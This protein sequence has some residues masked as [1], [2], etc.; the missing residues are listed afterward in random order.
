MP[1]SRTFWVEFI[2]LYKSLP[3]LWKR[4][5]EQYGNKYLKKKGYEL[6]LEKFKELDPDGDIVAVKQRINNMRTAFWREVHRI[7]RSERVALNPED[8]YT[9]SLWY[10][11]HMQF[12]LDEEGGEQHQPAEITTIELDE[13]ED[14]YAPQPKSVPHQPPKKRTFIQQ[15]PN[16]NERTQFMQK[17]Q[18][19][20]HSASWE[21]MYRDLGTQQKL[22]ANRMITEV[23]YQASLGRLQESS[24]K[25]LEMTVENS[26]EELQNNDEEAI[27]SQ[28]YLTESTEND[29]YVPKTSNVRKRH[30]ISK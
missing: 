1:T 7:R 12:L 30:Q 6:M 18:A 21:A 14:D 8:V 17:D 28:Y 19:S 3:E 25:L 4:D 24:Y 22:Y 5:S 10:F 2:D 29:E 20:A 13:E 27:E 11:T 23:L 16:Q 15:H 9:P 26:T